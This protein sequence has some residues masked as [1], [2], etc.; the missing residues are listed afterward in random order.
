MLRR[1]PALLVFLMAFICTV[2]SHVTL[3]GSA[4]QLCSTLS[5]HRGSPSEPQTV[6]GFPTCAQRV[7]GIPR[8]EICLEKTTPRMTGTG[9]T[10]SES[11]GRRR[12]VAPRRW[13]RRRK[14]LGSS[15]RLRSQNLQVGEGRGGG[16]EGVRA[17]KNH[18]WPSFRGRQRMGG[19][20]SWVR[21]FLSLLFGQV[22]VG[23]RFFNLHLEMNLVVQRN[24]KQVLVLQLK[25]WLGF[26]RGSKCQML[27]SVTD[28][29]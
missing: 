20:C 22:G 4:L 18:T 29:T 16:A 28:K 2:G 10:C 21:K 11:R 6:Q 27:G 9:T 23:L 24:T 8:R 26:E 12:E 13:R 1:V 5:I 19:V 14:G 7:S 17:G 15:Q 3:R 25:P